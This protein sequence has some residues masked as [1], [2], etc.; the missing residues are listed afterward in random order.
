MKSLYNDNIAKKCKNDLAL[1]V[2]TSQILGQDSNLVLHGGGNTSVKISVNGQDILYV[3]GSGWDLAS[4]KEEGFSPVKLKT[5]LDM[6]KLESLSDTDMVSQQRAAMLDKS[7]P[8]PSIEAILHAVIPYKF[9]DHTHSDAVVTISNTKKGEEY[10]KSIFPNFL[11]IPYVMPGFMLAKTIYEMAK[12]QDYDKLEGMIL[13][14]HGI[15]TFDNDAKK[16]YEKMIIAVTLAEEFLEK[17]TQIDY[18]TAS[19]STFDYESLSELI[20]LKKEYKISMKINTSKIAQTFASSLNVKDL[21]QKGIL[22]PE[23]IIRTKRLP[24]FINKD[25]NACLEK[26]MSEYEDYFNS[27][28]D[29]EICLNKAANWA[30]IKDLGSVSFGKNE[31]E[32]SIIEDISNHTMKAILQAEYLGGFEAISLKDGFLMEYWELEQAKL[33]K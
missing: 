11:I 33:K 30:V 10:I 28:K 13:L 32:A 7:A 14:N 22:T 5:L 31:K 2:Y 9:V 12:E 25:I 18:I 1:R 26:Y 19:K 6:A 29:E 24:L 15:F 8:N 27:F 3:K 16:A 20:S 4:I 23:H 21:C 17:N